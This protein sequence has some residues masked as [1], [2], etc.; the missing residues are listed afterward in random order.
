MALFCIDACSHAQSV[1][2]HTLQLNGYLSVCCIEF[3]YS[4]DKASLFDIL[5]TAVSMA[6][7]HFAQIVDE[8]LLKLP[9]TVYYIFGTYE[10]E[11]LIKELYKFLL[12]FCNCY[13]SFP[14]CL[15]GVSQIRQ[16]I[17]K[18]A[19]SFSPLISRHFI[20]NDI[21]YWKRN[22]QTLSKETLFDCARL[23]ERYFMNDYLDRYSSDICIVP[24]VSLLH[25]RI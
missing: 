23:E 6:F 17:V 24:P 10:R 15:F 9:Y 25:R 2:P 18:S 1:L 19:L 21:H 3:I 4:K 5:A 20:E 16:P 7:L 8:L 12:S 14:D 22:C 13:P 11:F